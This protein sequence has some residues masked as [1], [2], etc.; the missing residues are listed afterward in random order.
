MNL[1]QQ[2]LPEYD[3]EYANARRVLELIPDDKFE[4][5]AHPTLNT[6][7]WVGNHLA[8]IPSWLVGTMDG[9]SMDM[10]PIDGPAYEPPCLSSCRELLETFD[11]NVA[12]S[13]AALVG[14]TDECLNQSWSL[15]MGGQTI[16]TMPRAGVIRTWVLN[17]MIH[18]RAHLCVYLRMNGIHVPGMYGPSGDVV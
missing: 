7:G 10:A 6:I 5:R 14:A 8:E 18:H 2:F 12:A 15:L 11:R 3:E 13:R 4:W 16:F 1:A 17:H 9:D